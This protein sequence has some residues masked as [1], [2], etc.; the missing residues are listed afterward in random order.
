M[1]NNEYKKMLVEQQQQN[2][3]HTIMFTSI[4][5]LPFFFLPH[6]CF[7]FAISTKA[8]G[9]K[10]TIYLRSAW[11]PKSARATIASR[12]PSV[13]VTCRWPRWID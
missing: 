10:S 4:V 1:I 2:N 9:F 11:V 3:W 5:F 13:C 7:A 12:P 8:T 6:I